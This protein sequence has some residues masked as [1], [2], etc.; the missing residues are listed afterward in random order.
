MDARAVVKKVPVEVVS[1]LQ[2]Y[3]VG[4][5]TGRPLPSYNNKK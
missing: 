2:K 5:E 3:F 1:E 4:V